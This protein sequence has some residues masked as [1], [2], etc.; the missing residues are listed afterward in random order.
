MGG[1][2]LDSREAILKGG[3][4]GPAV[5]PGKAADSLLMQA[6]MQQHELKMPPSG[7]LPE[8]EIAILRNWIDGGAWWPEGDKPAENEK[9]A[10][11]KITPEQRAFWAFQPVHK[12]EL[13]AVKD[14]EWTKNPVDRFILARLEKEGLHPVEAAS[15][16][17]LIRRATLDLTGIP[18]TAEDIEAFL[19]DDSPDAFAKVVD[20]LL[21]SPQYGER[22]GRYWLDVAR[23]SDDSLNSTKEE[24]YPNSWRYRNWVIK[25][26]NEDMPY[27]TFVKAQIA[28]DAIGEPA[29]LGF[30][31]LSPEMQDDRVDATS[32]G[33]LAL[34]VACATCHDHKFDPIPTKDFYSLQ[35]VFTNTKLHEEPLAPKDV[36][37]AWEKEKKQLDDQE[38]RVEKFYE[39]QRDEVAEILASQTARY[40][41]AARDQGPVDGLD[42]ETLKRWKKY[43]SRETFDHPFMKQDPDEFQRTVIA[44][45]KEKREI[46][47]RNTIRL[48]IN[49]DRR[50]ISSASL[51][52]LERSKYMLWR[53]M[54]A[55]STKD[56]AGFF[57]SDDGVYYYSKG[58]IER[59]LQGE[60]RS[61]LDVQKAELERL[62][63]ALPPKYPFL[64]TITDVEKP[65]D[66]PISIRG[67]RNN[68]GAI[69]PRRFLAILSP[70]EQKP[71]TKGSGRIELA[72][73]I[74]D[75][76]NPLTARVIVNR[77]WQHHF[78]RGIVGTPSNFG[79]LGERPTHPELLDYMA[80]EFVSN[81][82]S[83]KKLHRE[84]MLSSTYQL[85]TADDKVNS[86]KDG[87]NLLLWR[88]N[89]NRLD[90][91]AMRDSI[92]FVSGTLDEKPGD[93]AKPL[94]AKNHKRTVYGFVSR[95]RL[96]PMLALFDFPNP[97]STAEARVTTNVP[98]QRLFFMNS[99]F[100]ED[101]AKALADRFS[102]DPETRIR[103][104]YRTVYGRNPEPAELSAGNEF[105]SS[106][107]D[108]PG[109]ARVLLSSNEFVF[110][111]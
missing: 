19:K 27:N 32:R 86:A 82:W 109:L 108:W 68:K 10:E 107:G 8:A 70:G 60:Y 35:G 89:R 21:A 73:A 62:T 61:Y 72:D 33:F 58:T 57:K 87:A 103:S 40:I 5:V 80:S 50:T 1:L 71:F 59:F 66:I 26:F 88:A 38:S 2:R 85:S 98:L 18:P 65:K 99:V 54:F 28:G 11:Y 20:R 31:A 90:A 23:Y 30:Y 104:M 39:R 67:D 29:G 53:D 93:L 45:N 43:L 56:A 91:E 74:A 77:V 16:R 34:T 37:D 48:G 79:Q 102:G 24:P 110:T 7:K 15:K 76:A 14:S 22:W 96:D 41:R 84:I 44:V 97:N 46:D 55:K 42:A 64:Q 6:V 94:D 36:V 12:P 83:L 63:K 92:L 101:Q 9:S 3:K 17:A 51:E 4:S 75:P 100:V 81:G 106:G 25:A 52:S 105:I 69:A 13:P 78:G 47:D 111:D 95:R 49:P